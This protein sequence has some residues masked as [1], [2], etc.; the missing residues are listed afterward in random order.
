MSALPWVAG[1]W[2]IDALGSSPGYEAN[3]EAI[4][5]SA[6]TAGQPKKGPEKV[7]DNSAGTRGDGRTF[8]ELEVQE[9]PEV[10]K[11]AAGTRGLGLA[12]DDEERFSS[13]FEKNPSAALSSLVYELLRL[14]RDQT[15]QVHSIHRF[16]AIRFIFGRMLDSTP[17]I[18]RLGAYA[19]L[20]FADPGEVIALALHKF[21]LYGYEGRLVLAA[22]LL[23]RFGE[24]SWPVL[25][26]LA[27]SGL[28]ECEYFVSTIARLD[29]ISSRE[30][31]NAMI[32]LA[33]NPDPSIRERVMD[34]LEGYSEQEAAEVLNAIAS[35]GRHD[36]VER[37]A[38]E[39]LQ[40]Q[41]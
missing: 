11:S 37:S 39:Q 31:L 24:R 10:G 30:R 16:K 18:Q 28:P 21:R 4:D 17:F 5:R 25:A 1:P 29:G 38:I 26:S 34:V 20:S 36:Q 2:E 6:S 23:S 8:V 35:G 22:S 19:I 14:G 12:I 32:D 33:R 41:A 7:D 13:A 15:D 9:L 40:H 3:F 27:K